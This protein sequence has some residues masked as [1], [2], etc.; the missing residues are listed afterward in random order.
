MSETELSFDAADCLHFH[1]S[2]QRNFQVEACLFSSPMFDL[3]NDKRAKSES[4]QRIFHGL[5][6]PNPC[7]TLSPLQ[8]EHGKALMHI[9]SCRTKIF[10]F[11]TPF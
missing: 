6:P 2:M 7:N 11:E 8:F 10:L 3:R 9:K 1:I 4:I 5:R